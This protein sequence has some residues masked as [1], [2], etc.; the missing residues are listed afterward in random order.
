MAA[1]SLVG[2]TVFDTQQLLNA[3]VSDNIVDRSTQML[4]KDLTEPAIVFQALAGEHANTINPVLSNGSCIGVETHF[5]RP[6]A[7]NAE[8]LNTTTL[9]STLDCEVDASDGVQA[10]KFTMNNNLAV[11]ST[12]LVNLA[13][14]NSIFIDPTLAGLDRQRAVTVIAGAFAKAM[15]DIR[16]LLDTGTIAFLNGLRTPINRDSSLPSYI[17]YDGTPDV[18]IADERLY[19]DI[20]GPYEPRMHRNPRF[21]TDLMY[22]VQNNDMAST[23]WVTGRHLFGNAVVDAQFDQNNPQSPNSVRLVGIDADIYFDPRRLD[24]EL[25]AQTMFAVERGSYFMWNVGLFDST[26]RPV[27]GSDA[28]F[29]FTVQ[30]PVLSITEN[31]VTRPVIY[32]VTMQE[33]CTGV[34]KQGRR[35][36]TVAFEFKYL[37]GRRAGVVA[38]DGHTGVLRLNAI[39]SEVPEPEE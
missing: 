39:T 26:P 11:V 33:N 8:A 14:C 7:N 32:N 37:G 21:L 15:R 25:S 34:D 31:G 22:L 12:A 29:E 5:L 28:I 4:R 16:E 38:G 9:F 6:Q 27:G 10:A 35:V 18:F 19:A 36:G 23:F 3:A 1:Q 20:V 2:S 13:D 30:D 17:T 24:S